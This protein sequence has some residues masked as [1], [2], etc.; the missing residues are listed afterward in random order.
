MQSDL[1][2]R[3]YQLKCHFFTF[4]DTVGGKVSNMF[5]T[6]SRPT[7]QSLQCTYVPCTSFPQE[8]YKLPCV[9]ELIAHDS[10]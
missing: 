5:N 3:K 1:F 7:L 10:N 4:L 6:E 8:Y 9:I 2:L